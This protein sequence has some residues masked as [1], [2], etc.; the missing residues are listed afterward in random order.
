LELGPPN[1]EP[2]CL[3]WYRKK[4]DRDNVARRR[5]IRIP[6]P[7]LMKTGVFGKETEN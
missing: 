5:I 6:A 2:A 4:I 1:F 3:E 7:V